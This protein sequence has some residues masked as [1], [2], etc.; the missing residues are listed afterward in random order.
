MTRYLGESK[1]S[2]WPWESNT[3]LLTMQ[4]KYLDS[5]LFVYAIG[6][7]SWLREQLLANLSSAT[8]SGIKNST[9]NLSEKR[10]AR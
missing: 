5:G 2:N 7:I 8:A 1:S 10:A 6:T 4:P 3:K 9:P